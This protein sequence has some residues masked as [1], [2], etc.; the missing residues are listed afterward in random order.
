MARTTNFFLRPLALLIWAALVASV[1]AAV[2]L[3]SPTQAATTFTV[4]N[5][6]DSGPGSL[7]QAI[8]DA[9]ANPDEDFI[10]FGSSVSGKTITL[11]SQ[12]PTITDAAGLTIDGESANITVSGNDLV[13]VF[14]VG[15]GAKLVLKELTVDKGFVGGLPRR[16]RRRHRQLR[17]HG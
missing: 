13:R 3:A 6:N 15:S 10:D 5:T 12:L 8:L 4:T 9:N 17:W 7:R 16:H 1:M 11:A 14:A 2:V